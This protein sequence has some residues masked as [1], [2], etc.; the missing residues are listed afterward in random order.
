MLKLENHCFESFTDGCLV[1]PSLLL[2][3]T[4]VKILTE[5]M[6]GKSPSLVD[7][8]YLAFRKFPESFSFLA[9][10]KNTKTL[11]FGAYENRSLVRCISGNIQFLKLLKR[12][13]EGYHL[14]Q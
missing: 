5:I 12:I 3:S 1:T 6:K 11:C 13:P 14:N 8:L 9:T 7:L 2:E 10:R 4:F